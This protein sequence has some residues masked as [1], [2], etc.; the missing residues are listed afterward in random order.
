MPLLR[1]KSTYPG[2]SDSWNHLF[3]KLP[4]LAARL[5]LVLGCLDR[6]AED[7]KEPHEITVSEFGRAAHLVEAY[8]LPMAR[9][10]YAEAAAPK[11]D[12]IARRLVAII[13]EQ[14]WQSFTTRQVL[15]LDRAGLG[16]KNELDPVLAAL[17]DGECIRPMEAPPNP[18]G[19]RPQR[20][21]TV[22]P[23]LHRAQP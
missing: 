1:G 6:A 2:C 14:G 7:A 9:R 16:S 4:G 12:R 19:G 10:A 3:G 17:E 5:A 8:F 23:A 21:Y 20:L 13:R 15:R 18:Q 11:A 22:N